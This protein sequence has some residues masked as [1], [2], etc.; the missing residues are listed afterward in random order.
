MLNPGQTTSTSPI[1]YD[2]IKQNQVVVNDLDAN[3]NHIW[4]K[5]SPISSDYTAT[6][7]NRIVSLGPYAQL[8]LTF[9]AILP[10]Y[11]NYYGSKDFTISLDGVDVTK[12]N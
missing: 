2:D 4:M 6:I 9:T 12:Q 8:G 5:D 1:P 3:N 10:Y 7:G 11:N